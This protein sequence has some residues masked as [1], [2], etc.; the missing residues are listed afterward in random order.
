[1]QTTLKTFFLLLIYLIV[2]FSS[3]ETSGQHKIILSATLDEQTHSLAVKQQINFKNET[4]IDLSTIVLNNWMQAYADKDT[5]MAKRF[6]DEFYRGFHLAKP[7]ERGRTNDLIITDAKGEKISYQVP[8]KHPDIIQLDLEKSLKSQ[9][10]LIIHLEYQVEI[11][12]H[13]FT[14][15]GY[16]ATGNYMLRHWYL[17]P[18][19]IEDNAFVYQSNLNLEDAAVSWC[20]FELYFSLPK[21]LKVQ[22][23]LDFIKKTESNHLNTFYFTSHPRYNFTLAIENENTFEIFTHQTHAIVSNLKDNRLDGIQKAIAVD[24]IVSFVSNTL[25]FHPEKKLLITQ[26]DYERNP[27][28]GLNQL[29]NF[30]SPFPDQFLYEIKFLKTY[31]H[32][33]LQQHL[34]LN[35]RKDNWIYDSLQ[36]FIMMQFIDQYYPDM[37]MMG[38]LSTLKLLKSY[39]IVNVDFNEQ[40]SYFYMLMARKNLDQPIG[41]PKHSL[42]KFNEQIAGKYR[43]GLSLKYLNNYL[44]DSLVSKSIQSFISQNKDNTTTAIDFENSLRNT[45]TEDLDWFFDIIINSR[46]IID[47]KIT[48]AKKKND[49]IAITVLNRTGTT[50]PIPL[51]GIKNKQIIFKQWLEN[52]DCDTTLTLAHQEAD[53]LV[54]NYKNEVPEYNLRNNWK[55]LKSFK[56]SNRP[57]KL[58]FLRDL[59]NPYYNQILYVPTLNFNL[60]DGLMPGIRLHNKTFLDKPFTFDVNPAYATRTQTLSG[61]FSLVGNYFNRDSPWFHN[62]FMMTGSYFHYAEDARYLRL[63]PM[64]IFRKRPVNLRDNRKEAVLFR[65]VIVDREQTNIPIIG[66]EYQ[67][68]SVFNIKYFNTRTEVLHHFS[69]VSDFQIA[70]RFGK[71]A[72]ETE[73]RKL[74]QNNRQLNLR[75]FAGAFI[76]NNTASDFFSFGLDRPTDYMFDYNLYGRS[77]TSGIFSQQFVM[78]E[79][80]FKSR[81]N[82]PYANAF[83]STINSSFSLWNWIEVYA[84]I[85]ALQNTDDR[86]ILQHDSGIRLNLVTDYFELY[87]PIHSSNGWEIGHSNYAER[88]R[89]MI[90]LSPNTLVTLFTRK[91]F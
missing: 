8:K 80:G 42:I 19:R 90:T 66:Q 3:I 71:I 18:S 14:K 60:Y 57:F 30:I 41:I 64:L 68:Y 10:S 50:V 32:Q 49:S 24:K 39:S 89:F 91:W 82:T 59:E 38:N 22:S 69:F 34:R 4:N 84:D 29:P 77:E 9:D 31:L 78:A 26:V 63:N 88:I 36:V 7:Q 58:N 87:F 13:K 15:F 81:L 76:Y 6:S 5:P 61:S 83:M 70:S 65:Q 55:S 11:P 1:M 48:S 17:V 67:N 72:V 56:V 54:L 20:A 44:G 43:A 73:F 23:D 16:D 37:K 12:N 85:G 46:D 35:P 74:Y 52:I 86:L 2:S 27:F 53:R 51:Y 45:T 62:R 33:F 40:Y 79:G 75:W 21:N 28:Y 47:Y 25:A